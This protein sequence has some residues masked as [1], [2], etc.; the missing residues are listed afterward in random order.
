[1]AEST[2]SHLSPRICDSIRSLSCQDDSADNEFL[3]LLFVP[4]SLH[5][6]FMSAAYF[7]CISGRYFCVCFVLPFNTLRMPRPCPLAAM[8]SEEK[9][10]VL[11]ILVPL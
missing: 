11:L 7:C 3:Q 1:M 4:E 9:S 2:C 5:L 10:A 6:F 8:I